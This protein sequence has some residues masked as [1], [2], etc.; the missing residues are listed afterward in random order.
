MPE[1]EEKA[2]NAERLRKLLRLK[3]QMTRNLR[4]LSKNSESNL[5]K[6]LMK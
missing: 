1:Q 2:H 3:S 6:E 5:S 4:Q